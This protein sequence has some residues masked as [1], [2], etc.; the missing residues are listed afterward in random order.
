MGVHKWWNRSVKR[1]DIL[2]VLDGNTGGV[3]ITCHLRMEAF[4]VS[5]FSMMLAMT[6]L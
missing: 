2:S 3:L 5:P 6:C 1:S 4:S